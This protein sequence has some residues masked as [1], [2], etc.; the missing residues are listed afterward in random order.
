MLKAPRGVTAFEGSNYLRKK[1]EMGLD[2]KEING[3]YYIDDLV[4]V[5]NDN[6]PLKECNNLSSL[7]LAMVHLEG[8]I[9]RIERALASSSGR[10]FKSTPLLSLIYTDKLAKRRIDRIYQNWITYMNYVAR[11]NLDGISIDQTFWIIDSFIFEGFFQNFFTSNKLTISFIPLSIHQPLEEQ[12]TNEGN[13]WDFLRSTLNKS[14][15]SDYTL[16]RPLEKEYIS[17]AVAYNTIYILYFLEEMKH[18]IAQK[19]PNIIFEKP[20]DLQL[21]QQQHSSLSQNIVGDQSFI[22]IK[23]GENKQ[24]QA[25]DK[26]V[27]FAGST[28][29]FYNTIVDVHLV[30]SFDEN[31]YGIGEAQ[32]NITMILYHAMLHLKMNLTQQEGGSLG[33]DSRSF[34]NE[35]INY[36]PSVLYGHF[37]LPQL[38]V[39][40]K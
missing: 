19:S 7:K 17:T 10:V 5:K 22:G 18:I 31:L 1:N 29:V 24:I 15:N 28:E 32:L 6:N 23:T 3:K 36:T 8:R 26:G 38:T 33:H 4:V 27:L 21:K 37:T 16:A 25:V 13:F 40:N 11:N 20:P 12:Y 14:R 39:A 34:I 35:F 2:E 9:S 30:D